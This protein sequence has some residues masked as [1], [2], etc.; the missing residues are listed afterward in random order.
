M[1]VGNKDNNAA[2]NEDTTRIG[3]FIDT[4]GTNSSNTEASTDEDVERI[5]LHTDI[6]AVAGRV[7]N[8]TVQSDGRRDNT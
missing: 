6:R 2:S 3:T 8:E 1:S 5:G 4:R 7:E